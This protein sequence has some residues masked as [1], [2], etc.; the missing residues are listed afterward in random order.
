VLED[1]AVRRAFE[2]T[3]DEGYRRLH[4]TVPGLLATGAVGGID[5]SLGVFG[6][7]LVETMTGNKLLAG[8]AF[9]IGFVSLALAKSELFT[10]N[11]LVPVAAAVARKTGPVP[12]LRLWATTAVSNLVG[13]WVMMGIIL[14]A[15]PQFD[16]TAVELGKHFYTIGIGWQSFA[17]GIL[18]GAL[19][20]LMTW[21]QQGTD[22]TA[23]KIAAAVLAGFLLASAGLFHAIVLSID[24]FAALHA[25][26][27]FGYLDWLELLGF[28]AIANVL[29][30]I[31]F[32]TIL[33]LTQV[34][35]QRIEKEREA[36]EQGRHPD[37]PAD[38]DGPDPARR[39]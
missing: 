29:G 18:G 36:V 32:V 6:I 37:K 19:I 26:A 38:A 4:R 22:S 39:R 17:S 8:L 21:M 13:G 20:T 2:K 25:G 7:L 34:G 35:W 31:G 28:A 1:D 16:A 30:G 27:P 10:E 24:M 5:V 12:V 11:F 3:V 14:V 23:G 9:S 15:L 33:R